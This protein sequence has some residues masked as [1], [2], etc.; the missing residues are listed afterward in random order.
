MIP[1]GIGARLIDDVAFGLIYLTLENTSI[2]A[3]ITHDVHAVVDEIRGP[4]NLST[5]A[6]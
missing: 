1:A 4:L 3:V 2:G 6:S 5:S